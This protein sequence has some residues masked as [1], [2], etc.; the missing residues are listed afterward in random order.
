MSRLS[1]GRANPV[2][3]QGTDALVPVVSASAT[4]SGPHSIAAMNAPLEY[5]F[6]HEWNF[7]L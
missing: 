6:I 7:I 4:P 3:D 2:T 5:L 1:T